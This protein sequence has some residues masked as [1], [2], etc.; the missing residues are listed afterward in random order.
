MVADPAENTRSTYDM[1]V[2][3]VGR[4]SEYHHNK[5]MR[6]RRDP[7]KVDDMMFDEM[8]ER[9]RAMGQVTDERERQRRTAP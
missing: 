3:A 4:C 5:M 9:Q 6:S 7:G 1:A 2:A 8:A